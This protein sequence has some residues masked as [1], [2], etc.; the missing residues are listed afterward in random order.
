MVGTV[1]NPAPE[2]PRRNT[3]SIQQ[4]KFT[5]S[6]I[7]K[8]SFVVNIVSL[9]DVDDSSFCSSFFSS[10]VLSSLFLPFLF[11]SMAD[12]PFF[13][14]FSS[15]SSEIDGFLSVYLRSLLNGMIKSGSSYCL[16]LTGWTVANGPILIVS[17]NE[18]VLSSL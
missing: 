12:W 18:E 2:N 11:S 8:S 14:S 17:V 5:K 1:C 6:T 13:D 16:N 15:F 9:E 10:S 3:C 4:K 7:M